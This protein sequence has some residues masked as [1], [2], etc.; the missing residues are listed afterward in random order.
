MA[1][2]RVEDGFT[3]LEQLSDVWYLDLIAYRNLSNAVADKWNIIHE[4]PQLIVIKNGNAV[5]DAS[6]NMI[7]VKDVE[8]VLG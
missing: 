5:Y 6:H 3:H 7:V 2:N 8:D 1:K 4:S